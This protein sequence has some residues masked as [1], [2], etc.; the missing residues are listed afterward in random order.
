MYF[1]SL[2][3]KQTIPRCISV[4]IVQ[5]SCTSSKSFFLGSRLVDGKRKKS[6]VI[7]QESSWTSWLNSCV[8]MSRLF[9]IS[10]QLTLMNRMLLLRES[11]KFLE[12]W[13]GLYYSHLVLMLTIGL[14][15]MNT[16]AY[17]QMSCQPDAMMTVLSHLHTL[18]SLVVILI[19]KSLR[20]GDAKPIHSL[21]LR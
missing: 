11:S 7:R 10:L 19:T 20:F 5:S 8:W 1:A 6:S 15:L 16:H 12:M 18:N 21:A 17:F 14:L 9:T 3:E 4:R 2:A 13:Q